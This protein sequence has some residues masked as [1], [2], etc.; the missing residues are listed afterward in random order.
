[1]FGVKIEMH[2]TAQHGSARVDASSNIDRRRMTSNKTSAQ[3]GN[4]MLVSDSQCSIVIANILP[5]RSNETDLRGL[6][7]VQSPILYA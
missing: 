7:V 4:V 6:S 5:D 1:M 2:K 3:R